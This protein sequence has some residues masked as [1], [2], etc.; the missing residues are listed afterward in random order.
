MKGKVA[1]LLV[2]KQFGFIESENGQQYFFHRDDLVSSWERLCAD[3]ADPKTKVIN[4][5][6]NAKS[7]PKGP[8][9]DE[10]RIEG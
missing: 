6:F 4:V 8:R 5:S 7:T 9:A 1:N 3:W 2:Q 10:V